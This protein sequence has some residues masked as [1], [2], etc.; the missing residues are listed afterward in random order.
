MFSYMEDHGRIFFFSFIEPETIRYCFTIT[1]SSADDLCHLLSFYSCNLLQ[2][3]IDIIY[4][5]CDKIFSSLTI[6]Y[7]ISPD[8]DHVQNEML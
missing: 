8:T 3:I 6:Y 1:E 7:Y 5:K 2:V 4:G